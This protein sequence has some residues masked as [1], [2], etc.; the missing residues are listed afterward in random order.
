MR[1]NT[2]AREITGDSD[3]RVCLVFSNTMWTDTASLKADFWT[4]YGIFAVFE[5]TF[6]FGLLYLFVKKLRILL[7]MQLE[8]LECDVT[9]NDNSKNSNNNNSQS[10]QNK[11][12]TSVEAGMNQAMLR[13]FQTI[14]T[15]STVLACLVSHFTHTHKPILF[16]FLHFYA[17]VFFVVRHVWL[18]YFFFLR[19]KMRK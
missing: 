6:T 12:Q 9:T 14:I 10:K 8:T 4:F 1:F 7:N 13:E 18:F 17:S 11:H 19:K 3:V 2:K 15:K 5:T 16:F